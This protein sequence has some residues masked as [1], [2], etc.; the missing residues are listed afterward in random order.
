M[1]ALLAGLLFAAGVRLFVLR[2]RILAGL[3]EPPS[4]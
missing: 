4:R 1:T 2:R 3:L